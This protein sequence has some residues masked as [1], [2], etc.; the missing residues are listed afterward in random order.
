[1]YLP[2]AR[3]ELIDMAFYC[4]QWKDSSLPNFIVVLF[5]GFIWQAVF[6]YC[7]TTLTYSKQEYNDEL[8]HIS[9]T[10]TKEPML[11]EIRKNISCQKED[12]IRLSTAVEK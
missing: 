1:M 8:E 12:I 2:S 11:A 6:Q 3:Q 4:Q 10:I 5:D 7:G 9:N